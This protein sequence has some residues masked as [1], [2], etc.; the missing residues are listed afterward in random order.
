MSAFRHLRRF[1]WVLAGSAAVLLALGVMA[2]ASLALSH[3][4][5]DWRHATKHLVFIAL[6]IAVLFFGSSIDYRALRAGS[7][8]IYCAGIVLLLLVLFFGVTIRGTRGWFAWGGMTWQP[9]E[10]IKIVLLIFLARYFEQWARDIDR[11][12]HILLSGAGVF[13]V[14]A[15]II[16]QPDM[17]S[18]LLL[19]AVWFGMLVVVGIRRRHF[20][21]LMAIGV[22]VVAIAWLFLLHDYQRARILT[23][24]DPSRDPLGQGY[25]TTQATIAIGS[26]R[27]LGRG[28]GF[29]SQ[30]QLRFL[31]EAET[32]FVFAV[33]AEELGFVG[34]ALLLSMWML[35]FWRMLAAI[36]NAHD[37]FALFFLLGSL[38]LFFVEASVTIGMNVGLLPVTG[39]TLPFVSYGGSSLLAHFM[40]LAVIESIIIRNRSVTA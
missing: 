5:P 24:F 32:D 14:I 3:D 6:G 1:D 35:F 13:L 30:S 29:G 39:I 15:L 27:F 16:I 21:T 23:F 19:F 20:F 8:S 31:P 12:R 4:P 38:L 36:R 17:G 11:I 2:I 9:V 33:I 28:F 18:A 34:T 37:D 7:R 40:I 25:N 10:F 26:G 22:A